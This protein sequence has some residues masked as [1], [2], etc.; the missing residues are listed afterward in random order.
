MEPRELWERHAVLAQAF[1]SSDDEVRRTQG[2]LDEAEA[3]RS[4]TL[5]AFAVT[6]G[7]DAVVADLLG[8][9]EREVRL[10]R[11]TV[12]KDDARAVAKSLLAE[13]PPAHEQSPAREQT[14]VREP[15]P[16]QPPA[17]PAAARPAPAQPA[18]DRPTADRPAPA[19]TTP[20]T[21]AAPSGASPVTHD[22]VWAPA[23]DAV[24]MT[25]WHT[26]VD[27]TAL[28]TELGLDVRLLVARAQQLSTET[29]P[30]PATP[31]DRTGRHR[32]MATLQPS[33]SADTGPTAWRE[34]AD[35]PAWEQYE[36]DTWKQQPYQQ[37]QSYATSH[38]Q[39]PQHPQYGASS[40]STGYHQYPTHQNHHGHQAHQHPH[41]TQTTQTV[42]TL[43]PTQNGQ[44]AHHGHEHHPGYQDHQEYPG[45]ESPPPAAPTW[46][47]NAI[48]AAQHD[49]DGILS[50]WEATT[51][52]TPPLSAPGHGAP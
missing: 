42:Q 18:A 12:G 25:S 4:R 17:A 23:L 15:A 30:A 26:G 45:Y 19:G 24:L 34:R 43:H 52:T 28:A 22:P 47:A 49:W 7:S 8:L 44:H 11:R 40:P 10:A 50:Q 6:V 14:T 27:L 51:P 16:A 38:P 48:T 21:P 9:D 39:H 29:R 31:P 37:Y 5:A 33:P 1:C 13:Q 32:R 46:D 41:D 3:R 20:G 35:R 36:H 2:L